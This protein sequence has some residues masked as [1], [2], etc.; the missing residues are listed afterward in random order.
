VSDGPI[1]LFIRMVLPD[2]RVVDAVGQADAAEITREET[3]D[4][5]SMQARMEYLRQRAPVIP[6]YNPKWFLRLE[7][8]EFPLD[9]W[10]ISEFDAAINWETRGPEHLPSA[11]QLILGRA[12]DDVR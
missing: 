10:R 1:R 5:Y 12:R 7:P 11:E 9:G 8:A 2:G 4:R 6:L 3:H